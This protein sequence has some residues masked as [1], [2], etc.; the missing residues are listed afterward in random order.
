MLHSGHYQKTLGDGQTKLT[1]SLYLE[2]HILSCVHDRAPIRWKLNGCD[3]WSEVVSHYTFTIWW[4][5]FSSPWRRE[6]ETNKMG[7]AGDE[8]C[9]MYRF[10]Q[11]PTR[12]KTEDAAASRKSVHKS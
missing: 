7:L 1:E 6:R 2:T 8:R 3:S 12:L 11:P 4:N 10:M 5:P 9:K